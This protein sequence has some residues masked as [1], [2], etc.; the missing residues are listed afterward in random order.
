MASIKWE[1]RWVESTSLP[2][3]VKIE[4]G[5][6]DEVKQELSEIPVD[7]KKKPCKKNKKLKQ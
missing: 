2:I 5:L 3:E 4:L 1:G 7:I 6:D